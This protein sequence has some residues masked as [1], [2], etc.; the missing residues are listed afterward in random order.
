MVRRPL[1]VVGAWAA[2]VA[3]LYVT[4]PSLTQVV[5]EH[6]VPLVPADSPAMA[7]AQQMSEAFHESGSDN[8]LLAVL[9]TENG[10]GPGEE[11]VYRALVDQ[12][13]QDPKDVLMMQDFVSRPALRETLTSKDNQAWILPI[14]LAGG[15]NTPRS[16]DAY[17]RV[18][19]V[20]RQ[21]AAGSTL[22]ANLAGPAATIADLND[23]G[24]KDLRAIEIATV[25]MVL[26]ILLIVYRNPVTMMLP[27]ITIGV[28]LFSA[29]EIVA[30]LAR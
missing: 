15:L 28:S 6:P 26:I 22:T 29:R 18:V 4:L 27:L 16:Q 12:L 7:T 10:L 5:H 2:L 20:I 13:R 11:D 1:I 30:G 24:D 25:V 14:G 21:S 3:T 17:A 8:V 9:T 23:A 19:D